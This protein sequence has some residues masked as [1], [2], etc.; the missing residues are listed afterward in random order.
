MRHRRCGTETHTHAEPARHRAHPR[1]CA[2]A[3]GRGREWIFVCSIRTPPS[4]ENSKVHVVRSVL[5]D[6]GVQQPAGAVAGGGEGAAAEL[7]VS[8]WPGW[9]PRWTGHRS[10]SPFQLPATA[11]SPQGCGLCS[12]AGDERTAATPPPGSLEGT[13]RASFSLFPRWSRLPDVRLPAELV[14]DASRADSAAPPLLRTS[15]TRSCL[16][17]AL[18]WRTCLHGVIRP[19]MSRLSESWGV[20]GRRTCTVAPLQPGLSVPLV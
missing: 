19:H 16:P 6:V 4:Q 10:P 2:C 13:R 17:A 12:P 5:R 18:R 14:R 8:S 11:S 20:S 9:R 1:A 7:R 15:Y 3:A